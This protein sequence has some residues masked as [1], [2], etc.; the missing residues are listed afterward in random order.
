MLKFFLIAILITTL[1]S[2]NAGF[3]TVISVP[4]INYIKD[5][6]MEVLRRE[7]PNI[8]IPD[9]YRECGRHCVDSG[10]FLILFSS[11]SNENY[12]F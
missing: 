11:F 10:N 7:L 6:G 5:V 2:R 1:F 9:H 12:W 4:G 8:K 3:K